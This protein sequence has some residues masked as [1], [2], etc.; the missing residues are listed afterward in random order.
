MCEGMSFCGQCIDKDVQAWANGLT[1]I[2][3]RFGDN[4]QRSTAI[5]IR[6]SV[7]EHILRTNPAQAYNWPEWDLQ[8]GALGLEYLNDLGS[9]LMVLPP[10]VS[11]P[12]R[13]SRPSK[14]RKY[15]KFMRKWKQRLAFEHLLF[16]L[17]RRVNECACD[18]QRPADILGSFDLVAV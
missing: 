6:V 10:T 11:C 16:Q 3:P 13:N 15:R 7:L 2:V 17:R 18:D 4:D 12:G 14:K 8:T 9:V 1:H 5:K